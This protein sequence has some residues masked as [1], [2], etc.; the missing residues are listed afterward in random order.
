MSK[1]DHDSKKQ[2]EKRREAAAKAAAGTGAVP[3]GG[4]R[5]GG[6]NRGINY[7]PMAL[8][9]AYGG[10]RYSHL[11]ESDVPGVMVPQWD[12]VIA[13]DTTGSNAQNAL[14]VYEDLPGI[15]DTIYRNTW[16]K[17]AAIQF[18]TVN[19]M[20]S[21]G[22]NATNTMGQ[23]E[24]A[25]DVLDKWLGQTPLVGNGGGQTPPSE[26]YSDLWWMLVNQ[27]K[28]DIWALGGKADLFIIFDEH[29]KTLIKAATLRDIYN[30][31]SPDPKDDDFKVELS[32]N[33]KKRTLDE[34]GFVLPSSDIKTSEYAAVLKKFYNVHPIISGGSGYYH[35]DRY[36]I[37]DA[38]KGF[39]GPESIIR[40]DDPMNISEAILAVMALS[41]GEDQLDV[42]RAVATSLSSGTNAKNFVAGYLP[43]AS[44]NGPIV[45]NSTA[46]GLVPKSGTTSISTPN[47]GTRRLGKKN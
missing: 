45:P 2:E 43:A 41:H 7:I 26:S 25:G 29:P 31:Q 33:Q 27:N 28:L 47:S 44:A 1:T 40:V 22:V 6:G 11:V 8:N 46:T 39:F 18:C 23:F 9:P 19:D 21:D 5:T 16:T 17:R 13:L 12:I 14:G 24:V 34:P 3:F 36:G 42:E 10:Y 20:E 4:K 38:W 15:L 35:D 37:V 30:K 32:V